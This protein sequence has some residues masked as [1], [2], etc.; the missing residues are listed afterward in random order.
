MRRRPIAVYRVIDEEELL[1][2]GSEQIREGFA[3][4]ED[5]EGAISRR[6]GRR[7]RHVR[8]RGGW[9]STAAA[10]A[11]LSASA[12]LLLSTTA[13]APAAPMRLRLAPSSGHRQASARLSPALTA[14][15][16]PHARVGRHRN[17]RARARLHLKAMHAQRLVLSKD[18]ARH[19]PRQPTR[20]QTAA[21]LAAS[22]PGGRPVETPQPERGPT[23]VA[24][25]RPSAEFGFER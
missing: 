9:G 3:L 14:P 24:S 6:A 18:A 23:P 13:H 1:G 4:P 15:A 7:R 22:A 17:H 25:T 21:P 11:G 12:A 20:A 19:A 16:R 10:V 5:L 2:G 8:L